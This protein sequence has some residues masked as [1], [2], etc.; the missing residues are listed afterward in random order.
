M[1]DE[2]DGSRRWHLVLEKKYLLLPS[3]NGLLL[4][5]PQSNEFCTICP[6][7]QVNS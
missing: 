1:G 3:Y 6:N 2:N 4:G 7:V 5:H